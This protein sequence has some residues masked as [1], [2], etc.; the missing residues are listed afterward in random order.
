[1]LKMSYDEFDT[2]EDKFI[3]LPSHKKDYV[4][5]FEKIKETAETE[6]MYLLFLI[7]Y[8]SSVEENEKTKPA[9]EKAWDE[10]NDILTLV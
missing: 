4:P 1:M 8:Q 5:D 10:I 3:C 9:I 6:Y 7:W 2:L